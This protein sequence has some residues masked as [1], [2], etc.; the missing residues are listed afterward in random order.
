M[1]SMWVDNLEQ[2]KKEKEKE[3]SNN[4][5]ES[6]NKL[7]KSRLDFFNL[8]GNIVITLYLKKWK[9]Q[10]ASNPKLTNLFPLRAIK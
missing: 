2:K 8:K 5:D 3:K 10:W 1:R 7:L 6:T 9:V 4:Q